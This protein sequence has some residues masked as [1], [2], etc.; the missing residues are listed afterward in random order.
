M[1]KLTHDE[2]YTLRAPRFHLMSRKLV[3]YKQFVYIHPQRLHFSSKLVCCW[4]CPDG[5][6]HKTIRRYFM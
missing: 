5:S 3:I 6:H 1:Q 2:L 4:C